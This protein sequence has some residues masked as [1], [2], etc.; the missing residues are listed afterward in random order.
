M[1]LDSLTRMEFQT[2]LGTIPLWHRPGALEGTGP[3]VLTINSAF[4][5]RDTLS[6]LPETL[7]GSADVFIMHMPGGHA[8]QLKDISFTAFAA[9]VSA[10]SVAQ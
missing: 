6:R 4:V 3:V 10:V 1:S 2:T 7:S 5:S 9:A 8:P